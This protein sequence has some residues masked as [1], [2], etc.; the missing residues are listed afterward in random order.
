M[1]IETLRYISKTTV[2]AITNVSISMVILTPMAI[3]FQL[4]SSLFK[5]RAVYNI[6]SLLASYLK[7]YKPYNKWL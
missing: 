5:V 3:N 1:K 6:A 4:Y 2:F 7:V